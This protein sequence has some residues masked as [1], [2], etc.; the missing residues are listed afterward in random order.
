MYRITRTIFVCK[1]G[2]IEQS[3]EIVEVND[4]EKHRANL[5][6]NKYAKIN[7]TYQEIN[8]NGENSKDS[9]TSTS[10]ING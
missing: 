3:N 9:D 6:G 4:L 1:D 7:F 10:D 8:D 2:S 5:K